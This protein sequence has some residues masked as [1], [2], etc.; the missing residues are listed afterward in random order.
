M[1]AQ[2]EEIALKFFK[3]WVDAHRGSSIQTI[4]EKMGHTGVSCY[5]ILVSLCAEKLEVKRGQTVSPLDCV[6][7]FHERTLRSEF[8][9]TWAKVEQCLWLYQTLELL[10]FTQDQT[11]VTISMPKL[12][13]CLERGQRNKTSSQNFASQ[14]KEEEKEE[15]KDKEQEEELAK[16][17][18]RK[19]VFKIH[20]DLAGDPILDQVLPLISINTQ[21]RWLTKHKNKAW[22]KQTLS[23]AVDY[24]QA[25]ADQNSEVV[26]DW[27]LK[28]TTWLGRENKQSGLGSDDPFKFLDEETA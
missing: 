28:L 25:R 24:H 9:L 20:P 5:W 7:N 21:E 22:L 16:P 4:Y 1:M 14:E 2:L 10:A 27:G 15:E 26:K 17:T 12:L 6:F 8:R 18:Q 23:K 19:V 13:E 11:T 3:H